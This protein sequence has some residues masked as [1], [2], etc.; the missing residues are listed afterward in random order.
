MRF[1]ENSPVVK[2][3]VILPAAGLGTQRYSAAQP[4]YRIAGRK[5]RHQLKTIHAPTASKARQSLVRM[6][7]KF[8]ASPLVTDIVVAVRE[9]EIEWVEEMLRKEGRGLFG[10]LRVV[11]GETHGRNR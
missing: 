4:H 7:R 6:M 5:S 8:V 9:E 2:T 10:S 1:P 11:A 3:A